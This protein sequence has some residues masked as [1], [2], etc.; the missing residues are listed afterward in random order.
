[1]SDRFGSWDDLVVPPLKEVALMGAGLLFL[2]LFWVVGL[3][4]I[5]G[6]H[7]GY[8]LATDHQCFS[9]VF[10]WCK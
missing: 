2:A 8:N 1:L 7:I 10:D 6:Y 9:R 3:P 5:H 4:V